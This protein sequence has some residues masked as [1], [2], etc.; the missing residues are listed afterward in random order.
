MF[1]A[2]HNEC[3][4]HLAIHSPALLYRFTFPL[5]VPRVH[6]LRAEILLRSASLLKGLVHRS[7]PGLPTP[8]AGQG[9]PECGH[10]ARLHR[11]LPGRDGVHL[12]V[13]A[14]VPLQQ[15]HP[16]ELKHPPRLLWCTH[17]FT[18]P[19]STRQKPLSTL[20]HTKKYKSMHWVYLVFAMW[21]VSYRK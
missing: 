13:S 5:P 20:R 10:A 19:Q 18:P 9:Q 4:P 17:L 2:N 8:R 6:R 7:R 12:P 21:I 1:P 11:A 16:L 3:R 15:S 14:G